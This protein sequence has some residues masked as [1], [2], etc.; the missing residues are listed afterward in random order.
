M[1]EFSLTQSTSQSKSHDAENRESNEMKVQ[2]QEALEKVLQKAPATVFVSLTSLDG[3]SLA[4]A[5]A[6]EQV[7]GQRVA[8]ISSSI[9]S[10]SEAFGR[11]ILNGQCTYN[12]ISTNFGS[13]VTI[14]VPSK[15]QQYALS[16]CAD[17]S[18]NMAMTLRITMDT[19]EGMAEI[20]DQRQTKESLT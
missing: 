2:C 3:R 5:S 16:V 14:R 7:K 12:A 13:I 20:I 8:A 19:A 10:L 9:M 18:E 1:S 4:F 17:R 11:E 15:S 6:N